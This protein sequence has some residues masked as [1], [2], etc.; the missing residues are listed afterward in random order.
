M[1]AARRAVIV[2]NAHCTATLPAA[3]GSNVR[4]LRAAR[5]YDLLL[6][7]SRSEAP[8]EAG[9][10]VH[11]RHVRRTSV[12]HPQERGNPAETGPVADAGRD[13]NY[14]TRYMAAHDRR[15]RSFHA[16]DYDDGVGPL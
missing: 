1:N 13:G 10:D 8:S 6:D 11:G 3:F 2:V 14:G 4:S 15:E 7:Q 12:E 9:I 5:G 16:G